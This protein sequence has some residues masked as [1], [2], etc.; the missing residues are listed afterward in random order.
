MFD[1][2]FRKILLIGLTSRLLV[3][4]SAIIGSIVIGTNP[5]PG[6]F[7][8]NLP[9][10]NLFSRWDGGQYAAIAVSGYASGNNPLVAQ[11]AW[12]P[13]YPFFMGIVAR[14]FFVI[15]TQFEAA[16]LAGFLISNSLFF[17]SLMIFYKLSEKILKDKKLALLSS[18]FFAFW[19][20][21]LFYSCIYSESL[22]MTFALGAFYFL[23]KEKTI[24]STLLG[25]LAALTRSN[26]FLVAIP[27]LYQGLKK[28]NLKIIIQLVI[29]SL[30]YLLFTL[31]G[32]FSTGVFP[33]REIV[34]NQYWGK[35]DFLLVQL[36]QIE[37]GYA[38]LFFI[39]FCLILLPFAYLFSSKELLV[40]VFSLGLKGDWE[41]AKYYGYSLIQLVIVL[42]YSIIRNI[43]RYAIPMLPLYWVFAILWNK[44]PKL[45]VI[46]LILMTSLLSIGTILFSTW[47]FYW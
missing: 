35:Q 31:F 36:A 47:R 17:V 8:I 37:Q 24:E 2:D 9:I 11:W 16:M 33:V 14:L 12:F 6:I 4:T 46:L 23:E 3:F 1:S 43:H 34:I 26:G 27:F 10:V 7:D 15:L 39:E 28:K 30:P 41:D 32:Y 29:F 45:G 40:N 42:V 38:L 18:L 22:F 5:L 20:G 21:S 13:L 19:P 44:K 25:F